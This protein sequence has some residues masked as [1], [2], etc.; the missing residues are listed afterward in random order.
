MLPQR[1][2]NPKR[3][4]VTPGT[5]CEIADRWKVRPN[6]IHKVVQAQGDLPFD[7]WIFS[8]ARSR[9]HQEEVS[10]TP[11]E[12]STHANRDRTGCPRLATGVDV[13]PVS[14]GVRAIKA[15]VA[16][17]GAAL[18]LRGLRW[19]GGAPVD[20]TGVPVGNEAWH[21]DLGPRS[22]HP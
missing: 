22:T 21:V 15:A 17:M 14:P 19:G 18:T 4:L 2:P 9:E 6:L 7:L 10:D 8:G 3:D 16:Q 1:V 13:Q 11:F 5:V 12:I 20:D